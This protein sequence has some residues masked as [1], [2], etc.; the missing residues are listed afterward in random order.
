MYFC[1]FNRLIDC[2]RPSIDTKIQSANTTKSI[3]QKK[4]LQEKYRTELV[5]IDEVNDNSLRV[6]LSKNRSLS[7]RSLCVRVH[8]RAYIQQ[9]N[10][11]RKS[12]FILNF[13]FAFCLCLCVCT[14][15]AAIRRQNG[16]CFIGDAIYRPNA[17]NVIDFE[18]MIKQHSIYW[19]VCLLCH[20]FAHDIDFILFF[21]EKKTEKNYLLV[22]VVIGRL[23]RSTF[24]RCR[25][26]YPS[27]VLMTTTSFK[28][29]PS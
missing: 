27:H 12:S 22:I 9:I 15:M 1:W 26:Q 8:L 4:D 11:N 16:H 2:W 28:S 19:L 21:Y 6:L 23:I 13:L 25:I 29:Y 20:A 7:L 24:R 5:L 18:A 17:L 14:L 10:A 3:L